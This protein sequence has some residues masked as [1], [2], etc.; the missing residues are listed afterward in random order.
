MSIAAAKNFLIVNKSEVKQYLTYC[1]YINSTFYVA[2]RIG[3]WLQEWASTR[4]ASWG[5]PKFVSIL[6]KF[7]LKFN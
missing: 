6:M 2:L 7:K 1:F 3:R 4:S 5:T